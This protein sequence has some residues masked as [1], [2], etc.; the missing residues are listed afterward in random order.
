[1]CIIINIE[2]ATNVCSVAVSDNSEIIYK[3]VD[4]TGPSHAS[5]LGV[6]VKD[7]VKQIKD[8]GIKPDA[9]AVSCGPGSYTG[10]R[11]GVSEAKGLCYGFDIPLIVIKTPLIMSEAVI[12]TK[13]IKE[14]ELLCPMIDARRMEVYT[15]IYD[16]NLNIISDI[17]A[18]IVDTETYKNFLEKNRVLFF[19]NGSE[20]CKTIITEEHAV[21]ID[22]IYPQ[23]RYMANLSFN[24][25]TS[26]QF[27]DV[28]Y[29]EPFYLKDFV[30]TTSKKNMF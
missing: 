15:A 23:A 28:A 10:L 21:F 2:T 19:G 11:I 20:K 12:Q 1:M 13:D 16:R 14:D 9:V 8:K 30:A 3:S 17:S 18:E 22:N 25:Y 5:I 4:T 24:A 26:G 6:F 7:A 27:V 29:F